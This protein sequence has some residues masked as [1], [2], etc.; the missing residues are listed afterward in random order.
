MLYALIWFESNDA[1]SKYEDHFHYLFN[2]L[3]KNAKSDPFQSSDIFIEVNKN[4]K[5]RLTHFPGVEPNVS[6][7]PIA[8]PSVKSS[9]FH[10]TQ[11]FTFLWNLVLALFYLL[12]LFELLQASRFSIHTQILRY[13]A[14]NK[15][16]S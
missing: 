3:L 2:K 5:Y 1:I 12:F 6:G 4:A 13:Q 15:R 7:E 9:E 10:Y 8:F 14:H 11:E 16:S